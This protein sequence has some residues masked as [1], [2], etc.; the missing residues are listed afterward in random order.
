MRRLGVF[1][2]AM[3]MV[4]AAVNA[5][6]TASPAT[7]QGPST[8]NPGEPVLPTPD[9]SPQG[10]DGSLLPKS[11]ELPA[12]PPKTDRE[13]RSDR[14]AE[15]SKPSVDDGRF[16]EVRSLAMD[17]PHAAYLLKRARSSSHATSRRAYLRAYY[18]ALAARMRKLDPKLKTSINA[19]E[20]SKIREIGGAGSSGSEV[21]HSR[22]RAR[23]VASHELRRRS[24]GMTSGYRRLMIIYDPYGS[25]YYPFPEP[26][27][28]GP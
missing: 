23:R 3:V 27:W 18:V 22:S 21:S 6:D 17:S 13:S 28:F 20:E 8:S 10:P 19:Y 2:L 26:R 4:V 7:G 11:G 1:T 12:M 14:E 16:D 9:T 5:Q 25:Q 24:H 15:G